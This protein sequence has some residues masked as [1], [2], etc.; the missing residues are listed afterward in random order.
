MYDA[1][2]ENNLI[3]VDIVATMG[4]YTSLQPDIDEAKVKAAE[5]IAQNLDIK[6]VLGQ[7]NLDRCISP[8]TDEDDQLRELIIPALCWFTYYRLLKLFP[9]VY[10][11]GGYVVEE[12][13]EGK[14]ETHRVAKEAQ[15]VA[16]QFLQE[17]V[18]FIQAEDEIT[19]E[20]T[21]EEEKSTSGIRVFGG[22]ER[23][24]SN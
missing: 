9:G 3:L 16:E 13:A 19:G 6:K 18:E 8:Q 5:N 15:S 17:A 7:V 24:A 4:D 22:E 20:D 14:G 1:R 2:L 11:D 12:G 10:T 23:R 21:V